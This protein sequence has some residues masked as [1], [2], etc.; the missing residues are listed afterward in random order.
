[1]ARIYAWT[2]PIQNFPIFR[3]EDFWPS[4]ARK[5][6]VE[7]HIFVAWASHTVKRT[8]QIGVHLHSAKLTQLAG[9]GTGLSRCISYWTWRIIPAI[10]MLFYQQGSY[11]AT[12]F[13]A[14]SRSLHPRGTTPGQG[15]G[16]SNS[17]VAWRPW[18]GKL[19]WS[20]N[21]SWRISDLLGE[22]LLSIFSACCT[23]LL[24]YLYDFI[25]S[26]PTKMVDMCFWARP[27]KA[28]KGTLIPR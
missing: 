23:L 12:T 11:P 14:S 7:L 27:V 9:N 3:K 10:A 1:M 21:F 18:E 22:T 17:L 28:T 8:K 13:H 2:E 19:Q 5:S 4:W 25:C 15:G 24:V 6:I 26:K 20:N 16:G